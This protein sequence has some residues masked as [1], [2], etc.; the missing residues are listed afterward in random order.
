MKV[1]RPTSTG[2]RSA[3][4][5]GK[6]FVKFDSIASAQKGLAAL[7]GRKFADRTVVATNFSEVSQVLSPYGERLLT[8]RKGL[9]RL[10]CVVKV[11]S[12]TESVEI[13]FEIVCFGDLYCVRKDC[14]MSTG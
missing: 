7:A 9:L 6:I 11:S 5:V 4:G 3:P 1:P 10:G 14:R 13:A 12:D 8:I 2:G